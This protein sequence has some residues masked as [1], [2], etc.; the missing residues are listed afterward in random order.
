MPRLHM[1]LLYTLAGIIATGRGTYSLEAMWS[2]VNNWL[3]QAGCAKQ[4]N[5]SNERGV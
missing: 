4:C 1:T 2:N 5:T 3:L